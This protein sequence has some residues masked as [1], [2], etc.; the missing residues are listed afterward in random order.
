MD[1]WAALFAAGVGVLTG[2][3]FG[4]A[5]VAFAARVE[6]GSALRTGRGLAGGPGERV[7]SLRNL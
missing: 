4:M 3:V 1:M 7:R 6:P 5:P 2:V